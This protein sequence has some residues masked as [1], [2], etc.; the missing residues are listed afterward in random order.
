MIILLLAVAGSYYGAARYRAH[1]GN[2]QVPARLPPNIAQRAVG[3][4]YSK[5]EAGRTLFTIKADE[6]VQYKDNVH[7]ELHGASITVFGRTG[8]RYDRIY[9]DSFSYDQKTQEVR[10]DGPVSI[11][12]ESNP[13]INGAKPDQAPPQEIKNSLHLKTSGLVFS[14]LTGIAR[15]EQR[16]E[17]LAPKGEGSAVGA[18]YDTRSGI[19]RFEH[20]IVLKTSTGVLSASSAIVQQNPERKV[21]LAQAL[22]RSGS[23]QIEAPEL[24]VFIRQDGTV[25]RVQAEHGFS[26]RSTGT[27]P[28]EL[29]AN[30]AEMSMNASG[31]VTHTNLSGK[32]HARNN[33]AAA[34]ASTAT[35]LFTD[36]RMR[37][38]DL[39][40][41]A[42]VRQSTG[43]HI[44][45]DTL[46][47]EFREDGTLRGGRSDTPTTVDIAEPSQNRT[48][49]LRADA[50]SATFGVLSNLERLH[51]APNAVFW[52]KQAGKPER[53]SKADSLQASFSLRDKHQVLARLVEDGNVELTEGQRKATAQH[54]EY[55]PSGER[56]TL[57]GSPR[58]TD[59]GA[60]LSAEIITFESGT[61]NAEATGK[62]RLT[63]VR[64]AHESAAPTHA[65]ADAATLKG[66]T[67]VLSGNPVRLWQAANVVIGPQ[68]TFNRETRTAVVT[69]NS[70]F[71][72]TA[73]FQQQ[74]SDGTLVPVAVTSRTLTYSDVRRT[75]SFDTDVRAVS[76]EG[77]ITADHILISLSGA[78]GSNVSSQGQIQEVT[79]TGRVTL[80]QPGREGIGSKLVYR[81][82]DSSFRL[83]GAPGSPPSI[84]DAEHGNITADSL[85][86]YS[87]DDRV[88]VE[89]QGKRTFTRTYVNANPSDRRNR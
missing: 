10:A 57:T 65:I 37:T 42:I 31:Q 35:I 22:V 44:S 41:N 25:A 56:A 54:A 79:A 6:L 63:Y 14:Q 28:N 43:S 34:E 51:A 71:P 72:A 40:G 53:T 2:A 26:S 21:T 73:N 23:Q 5:S 15:T 12:L 32:V 86:F 74:G 3:F 19:V 38:V 20:D 78:G 29:A 50:M 27:N 67:V 30:V 49:Q 17:V 87:R 66:S 60:D 69:G 70:R 75:A 88:L 48:S 1:E 81:A 64:S 39:H 16:V 76:R 4:S 47:L 83:T 52:S 18:I 89:S 45:S 59:S 77:S 84:F 68:I 13:P 8:D 62:V 80:Q 46:H 58:V 11:D 33:S 36:N 55:D 9:A 7:A 85:T 24:I 61:Q 82:S